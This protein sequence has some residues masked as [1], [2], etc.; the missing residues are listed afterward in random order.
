MGNRIAIFIMITF[1]SCRLDS[2]AKKEAIFEE[3]YHVQYSRLLCFLNDQFS[4]KNYHFKFDTI[5]Y[6]Q[7]F[8]NQDLCSC[9]KNYCNGAFDTILHVRPVCFV[10]R[11]SSGPPELSLRSVRIDTF[12][13]RLVSSENTCFVKYSTA[14]RLFRF[15]KYYNDT[16]Y[17]QNSKQI[18]FAKKYGFTSPYKHIYPSKITAKNCESLYDSVKLEAYRSVSKTGID[19]FNR[20]GDSLSHYLVEF[21]L[22]LCD[23]ECVIEETAS[24]FTFKLYFSNKGLRLTDY[25][26]PVTVTIDKNSGQLKNPVQ[27][28]SRLEKEFSEKVNLLGN[29]WLIF[30]YFTKRDYL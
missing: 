7:D 17:Y 9:Y 15:A 10:I 18:L 27:W 19:I 13:N 21:D 22:G 16:S 25:P 3:S 28:S 12:T 8:T 20:G 11:S 2:T 14:S 4:F 30:E 26:Y 24:T 6:E 1:W 5:N 29:D 23:E